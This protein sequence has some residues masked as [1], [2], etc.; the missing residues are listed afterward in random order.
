MTLK[1]EMLKLSAEVG[2]TAEFLKEN[3]GE[4]TMIVI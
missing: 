1:V 2:G 4:F 3:L